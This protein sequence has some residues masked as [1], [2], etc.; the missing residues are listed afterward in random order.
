MYCI[1]YKKY[2]QLQ[3]DYT[4]STTTIFEQDKLIQSLTQQLS[5]QSTESVKQ[6]KSKQVEHDSEKTE[7]H[8]HIENLTTQHTIEL[9]S[10]KSNFDANTSSL[11]TQI[12]DLEVQLSEKIALLEQNPI[13]HDVGTNTDE[14]EIETDQEHI[15]HLD[16]LNTRIV[17][18]EDELTKLYNENEMLTQRLDDP[19]LH[20]SIHSEFPPRS[21]SAKDI[22]KKVYSFQFYFYSYI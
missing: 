9:S 1:F 20:T 14:I 10:L 21:S 6:L 8:T 19:T 16:S 22:L 18:L 3:E 4:N 2:N 15:Q 12:Q 7:L 11:E 5:Q 13:M 17:E